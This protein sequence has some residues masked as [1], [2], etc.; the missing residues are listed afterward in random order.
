MIYPTPRA[1]ALLQPELAG[2]DVVE[3]EFLLASFNACATRTI[4]EA[5]RDR[6][7]LRL[8]NESSPR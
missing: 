8:L 3:G 6:G 1:R 7:R 2:G 4:I 5:S